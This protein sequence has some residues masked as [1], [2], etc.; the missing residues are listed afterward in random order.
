MPIFMEREYMRENKG[1]EG[2]E[3]KI[4]QNTCLRPID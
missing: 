1:C 4:K 3:G 2:M